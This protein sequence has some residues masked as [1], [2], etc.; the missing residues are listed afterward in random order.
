MIMSNYWHTF[1]NAMLSTSCPSVF[2]PGL[3]LLKVTQ[4]HQ[5]VEINRIAGRAPGSH[6]VK[7]GSQL[8]GVN[9]ALPVRGNS[10]IPNPRA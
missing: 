3:A 8:G 10:F 5:L 1:D 7:L 2:T 4:A 6:I 9:N